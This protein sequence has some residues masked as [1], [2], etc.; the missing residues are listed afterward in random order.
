MTSRAN[1]ILAAAVLIV[2]VVAAGWSWR[3]LSGLRAWQEAAQ[4]RSGEVAALRTLADE[5]AS[6]D[7]CV[8]AVQLAARQRRPAAPSTLVARLLPGLQ[9]EDVRERTTA[10]DDGWTQQEVEYAF[11]DAPAAGVLA[12]ASESERMQPPWR[13]EAFELRASA[14]SPGRGD[15]LLVFSTIQPPP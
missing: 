4:R 7:A 2:W 11:R 13:V 14:H 1:R 12:L 8:E 10:L 15:A 5:A 9:P 6:L 3:T